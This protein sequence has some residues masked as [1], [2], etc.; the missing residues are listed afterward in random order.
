MHQNFFFQRSVF[1]FRRGVKN[2]ASTN[3]NREAFTVQVA[4]NST[5]MGLK[6]NEIFFFQISVVFFRRGVTK[7]TSTNYI[8]DKRLLCK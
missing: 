7:G 3:Y 6:S 1:F 8:A 4:Q 2:G 5:I